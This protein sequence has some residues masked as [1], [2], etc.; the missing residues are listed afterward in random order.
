M[1]Y[2]AGLQR[3]CAVA[4]LCCCVC[5]VWRV[6]CLCGRLN[7]WAC[8]FV[9]LFVY[10][11][12]CLFVCVVVCVPGCVCVCLIALLFEC[13]FGCLIVLVGCLYVWC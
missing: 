13:M 6:D 8:E 1:C 9:W 3:Y 2:V 5:V 11:R 4:L 7:A 12:C 10:V